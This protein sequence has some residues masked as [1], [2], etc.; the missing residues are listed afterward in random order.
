MWDLLWSVAESTSTMVGF[1]LLVV[2]VCLCVCMCVSVSLPVSSLEDAINLSLVSYVGAFTPFSYCWIVFHS[3]FRIH[4]I[5]L[6]FGDV[7]LF[8]RLLC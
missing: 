3:S 5:H 1:Y 7:L 2:L 4:F 6:L 8:W